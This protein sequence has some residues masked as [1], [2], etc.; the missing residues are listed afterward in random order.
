MH[1]KSLGMKIFTI[2]NYT[3]LTLLALTCLLPMINQLAIS[4]S[5]SSAVAAGDVGL[6]PVDFTLDS[7][8]YMADKPEF[9]KSLMVSLKRILI[10]VPFSMII[11]VLAAFPL[12]RQDH[13]FPARKYYI[14]MFVVPMLIGGGLIPTYIVVRNTGLIDSIWA[15]VLPY[16]VNVFNTILLMNFFRSLPKELEEAAYVDGATHWQVLVR[17]IL[18]VSKPVLATVT[19][20]VIVNHWN[21]WFDGLI[22]LNSPDHYPLQT[23]LQTQVV[24]ANLMALESLRDIRQIGMISDRTGKASQIFLAAVP[25]LMI[26]PFLQKYFTAGIVMGSVKG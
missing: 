12:S 10:A 24:S 1:K 13:E 18:P 8:K 25:V 11:C 14:W 2:F 4:F 5:S 15:L 22:Y 19:L 20:F 16:T 21:S 26:Y 7:Y 23:Y 3:F 6:F 17:I 9:W